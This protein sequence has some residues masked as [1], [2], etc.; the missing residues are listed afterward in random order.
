SGRNDE[1]R[2]SIDFLLLMA[3]DPGFAGRPFQKATLR[4]IATLRK[5]FPRLPIGVDIGMNA[6][7]I[8]LVRRAG[9][10]C[11]VAGSA[12][13]GAEDPVAAYRGLVRAF[14]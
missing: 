13:F 2:D 12:I 7:T 8:P 4:R 1:R 6:K 10:S 14:T 9:A 11:A 5:Q 3:N